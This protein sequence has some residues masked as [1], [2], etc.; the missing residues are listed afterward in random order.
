MSS[1]P[2]HGPCYRADVDG[3]RAIAI[4]LVIAFHLSPGSVPGGFVGVD[5][6]FVISG[7]VVTQATLRHETGR[8]LRDFLAFWR[9]RIARIYPA[10]AVCILVT[11]LGVALLSPIF[12]SVVYNS[13][14]RT[15][16]AALFGLANVYLDRQ[17]T[18]YFLQDQGAANPFLHTWS[19]GVEEQFY[20]LFAAF[21]ILL[22]L[23]LV[24][25]GRKRLLFRVVLFGAVTIASL[26]LFLSSAGGGQSQGYFLPQYRLWQLGIGCLLGLWPRLDLGGHVP[27]TPLRFAVRI[28]AAGVLV[29]AP[30][31][32][33]SGN[34]HL[35][36]VLATLSAA[37]LIA[38]PSPDALGAVLSSRPAR[39]IGVRSYSLYLWHWPV[40]VFFAFTV[41]LHT[42]GTVALS[43]LLTSVLAMASYGLI[44]TPLRR[45]GAFW[46][47]VAPT[48]AASALLIFA[49]GGMAE[50]RP[51]LLFAGRDQ[52]WSEEWL[53]DLDAAYAGTIA[54]GT[55]DIGGF[56]VATAVPAPCVARNASAGGHLI[57]S[58]GDSQAFA[59]WGMLERGWRE[60][61]FDW[62]AYSHDGCSAADA[63]NPPVSS[64]QAYWSTMSE[65]V[66]AT[67]NTGDVLFVAILWDHD[68]VTTTLEALGP[69]VDAAHAKGAEVV[70]QAPLPAFERDAF[71]CTDE[72][73]RLD[74]T[75]CSLSREDFE[76]ARAATLAE[77][78]SF[79][80][81]R[82]V[83]VW[84][85]VNF[86]CQA[87][88]CR[89]FQGDQPI[90]RDRTH[91][92]YAAA[93]AMWPSFEA[94]LAGSPAL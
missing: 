24:G 3:L 20:L 22:G 10:L 6:F 44:E 85:P 47:R 23:L 90:F 13:F 46:V 65:R 67:V 89:Q 86:L 53:P 21:F 81:D 7:F 17:S 37:V 49:L 60:G 52:S 25:P 87:D 55:C 8:V 94:F 54:A 72:W 15:G 51:G 26:V 92:S 64:C 57:F 56:P 43:L 29:L 39:A 66:A 41:G 48:V 75:G 59:D 2:V 34:S 84:D 69:A 74:Y 28:A 11:M 62:A 61:A 30:L 71:N 9:R 83:R 73:F 18:N 31:F 78:S 70:I 68:R 5:V 12:P 19:L 82:G 36:I 79:A 27:A 14:N 42:V 63:A 45:P 91:L 38:V 76:G 40:L 35:V 1:L 33:G 58:I 88:Y 80:R 16:I 50:T 93:R 4:I 32:L 77:L